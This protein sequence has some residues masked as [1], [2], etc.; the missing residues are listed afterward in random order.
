MRRFTNQLLVELQCFSNSLENII[1]P[2]ATNK[3]WLL[4][5]ALIRSGRLH[6]MFYVTLPDEAT[7]C[8]IWRLSLENKIKDQTIDL[9]ALAAFSEGLSG[10]DIAGICAKA[11]TEAY[12][13]AVQTKKEVPINQ[14]DC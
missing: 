14:A 9:D 12:R 13:K 8:E 4:D 7:R 1:V 2:G 11:N 3:P 6:E 10:A 5:K